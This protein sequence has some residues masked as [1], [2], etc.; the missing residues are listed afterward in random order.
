MA[1]TGM[2]NPYALHKGLI[3][4]MGILKEIELY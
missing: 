4:G 1:V 2:M 3:M